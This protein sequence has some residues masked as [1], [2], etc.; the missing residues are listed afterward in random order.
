[1]ICVMCRQAETVDRLISIHFERGEFRVIVNGL[2][3]RVCPGCEESYVDEEVVVVLLQ[4]AE[5]ALNTGMLDS[6]SEYDNA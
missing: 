4:S 5:N 3:A 1:M 2:P 6:Q